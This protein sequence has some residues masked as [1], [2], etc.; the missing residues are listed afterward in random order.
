MPFEIFWPLTEKGTNAARKAIWL[1]V[2][3]LSE[4]WR[5]LFSRLPWLIYTPFLSTQNKNTHCVAQSFLKTYLIHQMSGDLFLKVVIVSQNTSGLR[6]NGCWFDS[7]CR[8]NYFYMDC[9]AR[10]WVKKDKLTFLSLEAI[11]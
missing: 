6:T 7:C 4:C 10:G 5:K 9:L 11:S 3:P 2:S 1:N 8:K